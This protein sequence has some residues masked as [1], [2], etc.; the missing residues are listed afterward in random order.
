MLCIIML[1]YI[2]ELPLTHGKDFMYYC[3]LSFRCSFESPEDIKSFPRSV[4]VLARVSA[5]GDRPGSVLIEGKKTRDPDSWVSFARGKRRPNHTPSFPF[6]PPTSLPPTRKSVRSMH[7]F[8]Q[9][10]EMGF[11]TSVPWCDGDAPPSP[12]PPPLAP[13]RRVGLGDSGG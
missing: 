12:P 2:D 7:P 3:C 9:V 1:A 4:L 8:L 5:S 11:M 13:H 10:V 6:L